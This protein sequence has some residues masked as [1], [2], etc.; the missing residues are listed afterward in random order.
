M[1]RQRRRQQLRKV[2]GQRDG[3]IVFL[4]ADDFDVRAAVFD[5]AI[6]RRL[7]P[8]DEPAA[9]FEEIRPRCAQAALVRAGER[10][11]GHEISLSCE[12]QHHARDR[13]AE[14]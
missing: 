14:S 7:V 11:A 6:D 3:G 13:S 9:S 2:T 5:H 12:R 4:R 8:L 10:M 1:R